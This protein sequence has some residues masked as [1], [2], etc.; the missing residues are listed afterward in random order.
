MTNPTQ[1]SPPTRTFRGRLRRL[2]Q[3]GLKIVYGTLLA[4]IF[5]NLL[6]SMLSFPSIL[7]WITHHLLISGFIGG[8]LFLLTALAWW[9][10]KIPSTSLERQ[11]RTYML[12]RLRSTYLQLHHDALQQA[13]RL[14]LGLAQM[15][16]A[17]QNATTLLLERSNHTEELLP[18]GT[19]ILTVFHHC[20]Q[21][22]LILGKPGAGKSTM[23]YE[24]ALDLMERAERDETHPLPIYLPLSSWAHKRLVFQ[25]WL[26]QQS[27]QL[28]NIPVD[29]ARGW[30]ENKRLL[31]LLDGL[32]EV[33]EGARS[34]CIHAINIYHRDYLTPLVVCSRSQEYEDAS[35]RQRLSLQN[36]VVVQPL[37]IK[38]V[39]AHLV[40]VGKSLAGL[41]RALKINADLQ[42]LAGSPLM[43]N[44]LTLAYQ[45]TSVRQLSQKSPHLQQ[46]VWKDYVERMVERKGNKKRYPLGPTCSRL[47]WLARQMRAHDPTVFYLEHVQPDWLTASEQSPYAWM[48]VRLPVIGIGILVSLLI[49]SFLLG[50]S[51]LSELLRVAV[52][53][54]FVGGLWSGSAPQGSTLVSGQK[55]SCHT[56]A[57]RL[58]VSACI[59]LLVGLSFGTDLSGTYTSSDWI[60]DGLLFG[61]VSGL[62]ALLLQSFFGTT[63]RPAPP[64]SQ[65]TRYRRSQLAGFLHVVGVP[66]AL[67]I[68]AVIGLSVGLSYGLSALLHDGQQYGFGFLLGEW[69]IFVLTAG[70]P[71]GLSSGL[72]YGLNFG[73]ISVVV[74]LMVRAQTGDIRLTESVN[75]TWKSLKK[76]LLN[77]HHLRRTVFFVCLVMPYYGLIV[78]LNDMQYVTFISLLSGFLLGGL[79]IGLAFGVPAGLSY[80]LLFGLFQSV[81]QERIEDQDRRFANQGIRYSLHNSVILG[82][83]SGGIIGLDYWL[84]SRLFSWIGLVLSIGEGS[85][86]SYW[87]GLGLFVGVVGSC[88][89]CL[90]SGGLA[91]LRHYVIRFR[92]TRSQT[93]P[94]KVQLFLD[95]AT[96]RILLRRIG[97]GY[98]FMHRLL[99]DYFADFDT[100]TSPAV[101][102]QAMPS[103]RP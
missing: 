102:T 37:S 43:L 19:S 72:L 91:V 36:A 75:W 8:G 18:A 20:G 61:T 54:G 99:L 57:T 4:G 96:T 7:D 82:I 78:G 2:L 94:W 55:G 39:E 70:L 74:G 80:W 64:M 27:A 65:N 10:K 63:S 98:S 83:I 60:N 89:V 23:L 38:E 62:G 47:S 24:I 21:E 73:L 51:S 100:Q 58:V 33:D 28:Y 93:F 6:S 17:V 1:S 12:Q 66:S 81:A 77:A 25:E 87:P 35:R 30:I 49:Q 5:V 59:G 92:L 90:H 22:L 71:S 42:E 52:L 26:A 48:A 45:G 34:A 32:D 97:G 53:G 41:R 67:L 56:R 103:S 13:I 69:Q 88:L 15:P 3:Q 79:F 44:V 68:A 85:E 84:L 14:E 31:P 16:H 9:R 46:Q 50:S 86:L 11:N 95:D 29:V 40:Q 76:S 101:D